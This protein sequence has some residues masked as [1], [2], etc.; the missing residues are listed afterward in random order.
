VFEPR[1]AAVVA[2]LAAVLVQLAPC[3]AGAEEPVVRDP[4]EPYRAEARGEAAAQGTPRYVLTGVVVSGTRR[5][6]IVN[7]R[8]LQVG[9]R[10]DGAEV[11]HIEPDAVHLRRE[12]RE[13]LVALGNA[14]RRAAKETTV[15]D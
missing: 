2:A 8:L 7:G 12:G 11:V 9:D 5:I 13:I 3:M 4:L 10:V 15:D 1:R 14:A 6:A